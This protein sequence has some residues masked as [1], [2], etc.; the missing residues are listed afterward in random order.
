M[1]NKYL[2]TKDKKKCNGCGVCTLEC[3]VNA[4]SMVEDEEGFFY[5][6]IDE[7]KC[8]KCNKCRSICSNFNDKKEYGKAYLAINNNSQELSQSAS[9]GMFYVIAK[10]VIEKNGVVFGVEYDDKLNVQH[11]YYETIEECKKFQGSKYV[12]SSLR[13]SFEKVRKFLEEDR[14]VLFTGTPCQCN[15]LKV[16]LKK[17]YNKLILCDIICHA[18]PSQKV[19]NKYRNELEKKYEKKIVDF[20]FRD[21]ANGWHG[22]VPN[23]YFEDHTI[24]KDR[25]F[26]E[27][28]VSELFNRPSCHECE[29]ASLNRITDF[30][31]GD[32]W[33]V[34]R[35][36]PEYKDNNTGISLLLVNSNKGLN[37]FE[38]IKNNIEYKEVD[39]KKAFECNHSSNVPPHKN[40]YLFFKNFDE[41]TVKENIQ[42]CLKQPLKVRIKRKIKR[43]IK[44]I[45]KIK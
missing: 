19:F 22:S 35:I 26:Y 42:R 24:I 20:K 28:F 39:Y 2:E 37:I 33:G 34:E 10:F 7:N 32:L 23:I 43:I 38:T 11:N 17:D 4:I 41:M 15:A 3:P 45:L 18:N 40:R 21:K 31:L 5:P 12:R 1:D 27:A 14:F 44:K 25:I 36:L 13:D 6:T 8:I 16:F 29:F 9:G 30:T